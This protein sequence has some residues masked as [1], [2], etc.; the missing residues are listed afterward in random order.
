MNIKIK[1]YLLCVALLAAAGLAAAQ[2]VGAKP[3]GK[4]ILTLTGAIAKTNTPGAFVFDAAM[5]DQLPVRA[6]TTA[7]PW[8]KNVGT[9][10]GPL[11]SD[12]LAM[13]GATGTQLQIKALNDYK[14]QVPSEDGL[15]YGAILARKIDG[16]TLSVRD[17]GP[18]FLIYPFDERPELRND[19][20]YGRAIWQIN[21][22]DV[23]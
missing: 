7:S 10:S 8:F 21:T 17:K 3:K 11:L 13:A 23:R 9:F 15:K 12:V 18:L 1:H 22:I 6:I 19:I 2:A 16:K 5:I 14:V 20:F 4:I